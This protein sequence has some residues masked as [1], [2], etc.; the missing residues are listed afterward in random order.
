MKNS[1]WK[2]FLLSCL[3]G[4][5][6]GDVATAQSVIF[7]QKQQ[8]GTANADEVSDGYV[9]SNDLFSAKFIKENGKLVFGGSYALGLTPGSEIFKIQLGDGTEVNASEMTLDDVHIVELPGNP[10]AVKGSERFAGKALEADYT[11][12]DLSLKWKAVLRNGS[13]Y[14]RTELELTAGKNT[15]MSSVT[16]MIYKVENAPGTTAPAVVGNTR[17]AVLAGSHIFAGLETPMGVNTAGSQSDLARFTHDSWTADS[18]TWSPSGDELPQGIS[19]LGFDATEIVGSRGYLIFKESGEMTVT[20]TY[21]SGS[22]RLNIAGIDLVDMDGNIVSSDYHTGYTGNAASRNTY[23]VNIPEADKGY[24]LRYFCEIKTESIT[25]SGKISLN[26][27]VSVP[28]LVFDLGHNAA[29]NTPWRNTKGTTGNTL[30]ENG[31]MTQTWKPEDWTVMENVPLR[32]TELGFGNPDVQVIERPLSIQ[33]N[34]GNFSAE[35][36]YKT[37]NNRL[38]TLGMDLVDNSGNVVVSDYH[39]GYSGNQKENH[40]YSFAIPY[41]GDFTLRY[42]CESKTE[43]LTSTGEINLKLAVTDTLHLPSP[44]YTPIQGVWQRNTTLAAGKTW[45]VSAVVGLIAE[46]QA[47][48]SFLA[49]SERE[50]AVP[51]RPY[52]VYISWYELNINRNNDKDYTGNMT[53]G[54]CTDVVNQ[55]KTHLYTNHKSNVKAF[56]WDDGWDQYGTWTFNKNFPNGF[57]EPNE[58]AVAMNSGIGAWLGPVGGYGQS[59]NYRRAYWNGKGGMQLSNPDYYKVF[60]DACSNMIDSYD[61]RFFKFD[62]ISAQFSATGPDAGTTGIEN[63]EAIIDI[64]R[65]I[66]EKKA[67]IFLNTTVGTWASPFWFQFTDAVWRQENDYGE[68]GN[69]GTSRE[70]WITYRDRLVYQNFVQNSPLC[71]IN[72]LMTHGFILS[73]FGGSQDRNYNGIVRELRCAFAC[74]SGMVELYN[75]YKLMNSINGGKLWKELADCIAWQ[76]ENADVLPDIHWVGGNPWDGSKANVYGWASWNGKKATLALRNPSTSRQTYSTTLREA[77]D[78]PAYV[79]T[80]ITLS[81]AFSQSALTGLDVDKEID[82]D[83][84]LNISLPASSVFVFNGTDNHPTVGIADTPLIKKENSED[85]IYDIAGRRLSRIRKG[86]NIVNGKKMVIK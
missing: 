45:K 27:K 26:K 79:N 61:F 22:H 83:T 18:W 39:L 40:I 63:A 5:G 64:E 4:W 42:F 69:Q 77:L 84:P 11:Y 2:V 37:G 36:V 49:Y 85:S 66:R 29:A 62:G 67:D 1:R 17:G 19:K 24:M 7:P 70:K 51:W 12:K 15:A 54:Q 9:L 57:Q 65:K 32:I 74:G 58:T 80:T 34:K 73:E 55:W 59:G 46:G 81:H 71:P 10:Q 14:L 33:S 75:D 60:L 20:F 13:H 23:K 48:R 53:V 47:R 82:I 43:P 3:M 72:T 50:R 52:P 31:T 21:T 56:V 16:P 28:V 86:I 30:G 6:A 76:E 25:S 41:E 78:I 68:I 35:F 44:A 38:N 8:A